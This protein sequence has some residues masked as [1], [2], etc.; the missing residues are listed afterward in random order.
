MNKQ[1]LVTGL[2][3]LSLLGCKE[4]KGVQA[5]DSIPVSEKVI[6][7]GNDYSE[8]LEGSIME[9]QEL[10]TTFVKRTWQ[11]IP[12]IGKD[13]Q[14]NLYVAWYSGGTGEG[15]GN[16]VTVS[17][18]K[19]KGEN[20]SHNKVI[21]NPGNNVRFFDPTFFT[22][23]NDN[24]FLTWAKGNYN[25]KESDKYDTWFT[26]ISVEDTL[27]TICGS[28]KKIASGIMMNKPAHS[29]NNDYLYFPITYWYSGDSVKQTPKIYYSNYFRGALT[30]ANLLGSI[31][32]PLKDRSFDEHMVV[33]TKNGS[34]LGMIRCK[35]GIYYTTSKD[36]VSWKP[37]TP[38]TAAGPT[39]SSRF[40]L[41]KLSSGRLVLVMNANTLR[42]NLKVF[43][44]DDD[45]LTWG[46][47]YL[48]DN[49]PNIS[50]PDLVEDTDGTLYIVYDYDR[51]K[52]GEINI[53]ILNKVGN[54]YNIERKSIHKLVSK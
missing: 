27:S 13:R 41:G 15:I 30:K 52:V 46:E 25:K 21:V 1:I 7:L 34:F 26:S 19:D 23:K 36:G 37:I 20:W 16:Y 54:K 4:S 33:Q 39:T 28:A 8:T 14:G 45:G 47:S 48:I 44:S 35:T 6:Y 2:Y 12:S 42:T 11:G 31:Y 40:F 43:F 29:S 50:Y 3:L 32:I 5:T 10:N 18:S 24:L 51:Y 49:R 22:D 53:A 9:S 38:F 17:V